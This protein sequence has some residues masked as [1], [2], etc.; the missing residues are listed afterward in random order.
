MLYSVMLYQI[1]SD[2]DCRLIT[3]IKS[4]RVIIHKLHECSLEMSIRPLILQP[5]VAL[6]KVQYPDVNLLSKT[7]LA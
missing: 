7:N 4:H 2:V 3:L 5:L 6:R 1:I